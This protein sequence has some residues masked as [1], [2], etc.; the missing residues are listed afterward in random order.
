MIVEEIREKEKQEGIFVTSG[1]RAKKKSRS[2]SERKSL[3]PRVSVFTMAI[4][5]RLWSIDAV[6][7][8]KIFFCP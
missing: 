6:K 7:I 8:H 4:G 1:D 3:S 2:L 5:H